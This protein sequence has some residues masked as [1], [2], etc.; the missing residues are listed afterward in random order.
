MYN[1]FSA[2][3]QTL[4]WWCHVTGGSDE[5]TR[6]SSTQCQGC[7]VFVHARNLA[8]NMLTDFET[9]MYLHERRC[10]AK[11]AVFVTMHKQECK[12]YIRETQKR[13]SSI[14]FLF[15]WQHHRGFE[16]EW[17]PLRPCIYSDLY[18]A[19][20]LHPVDPR[21]VMTGWSPLH[22]GRIS[23]ARGRECD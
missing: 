23:E 12:R 18:A 22:L 15:L 21:A 13:H 8:A 16:C 11:T 2:L 1:S 9:Q 4:G 20:C 3:D 10:A 7:C 6:M 14:T 5:D 19:F 17:P